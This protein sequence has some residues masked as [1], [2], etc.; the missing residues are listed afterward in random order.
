MTRYPVSCFSAVSSLLIS[1]FFKAEHSNST[2][3]CALTNSMELSP[4]REA[5]SCADTQEL[6]NILWNPKVYYRVHTDPLLVPIL[7]QINPVHTT[8]SYLSKIHSNIILPPTSRSSYWSLSFWLSHQNPICIPLLP[9]C[10]TSHPPWLDNSN[11]T[12]RNVQ[13]M[14]TLFMQFSP[15]SYQSSLFGPAILLSTPFS[16]TLSLCSSHNV[17]DQV[18]HPYKT[19]GKII[20]FYILIFTFLDSRREDGL[21][22]NEW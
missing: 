13:V 11:Y 5:A 14:K 18:S 22:W 2:Y 19:I 4:S 9:M 20:V 16:N 21:F 7:S 6:S 1:P 8:P 10:A 3:K 17:R 12:R 15:A